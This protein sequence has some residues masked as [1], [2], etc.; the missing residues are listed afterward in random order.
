MKRGMANIGL[1]D[2]ARQREMLAVVN[3]AKVESCRF[4]VRL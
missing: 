2:G 4:V 1:F 3:A